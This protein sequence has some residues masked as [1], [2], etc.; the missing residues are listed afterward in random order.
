[1]AEI[2]ITDLSLPGARLIEPTI[3]SDSRGLFLEQYNQDEFV[4]SGITARFVQ[5]NLS[6]S[7]Q[8]TLRG[9]HYQKNKP[10]GKL[11]TCLSG[12]VLDV[13]VDIEPASP[14]YLKW[15]SIELDG[16]TRRQLW[17]PPGFAHGFLVL[18]NSADFFY[19]CTE[20]YD[21]TDE[22]GLRWDDPSI[23][24]QWGIR[25]PTLSQRDQAWPLLPSNRL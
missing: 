2:R 23:D 7:L 3:F 19:K 8:G 11:V 14:N 10:Q 22:G 16:E 9:L 17:V 24:I 6:R 1:M 18:S 20:F 4:D 21:P 13:V 12:K 25:N 5:D 15:L